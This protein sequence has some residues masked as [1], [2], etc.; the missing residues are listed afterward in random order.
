MGSKP[1][2]EQFAAEVARA[3]G[4]RLVALL[5]Y[6][7]WARGTHVPD[8][9]D[10]NT[11][12]ICDTVDDALF[13][14]LAPA[15]RAWTRASHPAPL[16]LTEREWRESADAFPIEYEDMRDAHRLLAGRDP[17]PG[18]QVDR[19]QLRRQLEHELMGKLVRLRQAYAALH[20]GPKQLAR[21]VVGSAGGF[22]TMLRAVLRLAGRPVPTSP[23][24]LVRSAAAL[25]GFPADG[26]APLVQHAMGGPDPR[27][28]LTEPRDRAAHR[29]LHQRRQSVG[30]EASE[31]RR[32]PHQLGGRGGYGPTRETQH[33]AQHREKAAGAPYD[34]PRELF[35]VLMQRGIRLAQANQLTHKL[36]LKLAPQLAAVH[37]DAGPRVAP[38]E[39]PVRVAH[40]FVF[41]RERVRGLPPLPLGQDEG[42]RVARAG[43]GA[44]GGS[45][46]CK[47][48]IVHRVTNEQRVHVGAVGNVSS[49]R[50][51]PVEQQGHQPR[52]ERAGDLRGKLLDRQFRG[53]TRSALPRRRLKNHPRPR[54]RRSRHHLRPRPNPHPRPSHPRPSHHPPTRC[55]GPVALG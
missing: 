53:H 40:V 34:N 33:S 41:D 52:A 47:Q 50:P 18:I 35:R 45:E 48:S 12:L 9:S 22:F 21:V 30:R 43:P 42:R 54:T 32:A 27:I 10:V 17:W 38:R 13:A 7:S 55:A 37:L 11:L 4:A 46:C 44:H 36:V 2:V 51:R 31:C 49:T 39:Q 14:A 24:E 29:V 20:E 1:T 8:R 26:L 25:A 16:I 23:A 5:L 15:M 19:G 28:T 3:L 6:G